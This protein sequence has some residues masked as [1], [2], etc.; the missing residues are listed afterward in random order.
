VKVENVKDGVP[1][2]KDIVSGDY[3]HYLP[4][5]CHFV[6]C[7]DG[8]I[9]C[10]KD[11]N[12]C[13]SGYYEDTTFGELEAQDLEEVKIAMSKINAKYNRKLNKVIFNA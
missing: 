3:I 7:F 11:G 9:I 10:D 1:V 13:Q 6:V 12:E 8:V 2:Y 5:P 4:F